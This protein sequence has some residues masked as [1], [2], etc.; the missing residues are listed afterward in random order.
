[1][2]RKDI[3]STLEQANDFFEHVDG[4]IAYDKTNGAD[5][6]S[7]TKDELHAM[8]TAIFVAVELLK[9]DGEQKV[10]PNDLAMY[11][12]TKHTIVKAHHAEK[13]KEQAEPSSDAAD[14]TEGEND[15][16]E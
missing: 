2:K 8:Q 9:Y 5:V 16:A 15:A 1:M 10:G 7:V 11:L 14:G 4:A 6:T 12:I 3:I 13:S